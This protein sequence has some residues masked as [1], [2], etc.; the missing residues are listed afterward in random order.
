MAESQIQI[1]IQMDA[2]FSGLTV[3]LTPLLDGGTERQLWVVLDET[4]PALRASCRSAAGRAEAAAGR[5]ERAPAAAPAR[6]CQIHQASGKLPEGPGTRA[7][8]GQPTRPQVEPVDGPSG[9][10]VDHRSPTLTPCVWT[11]SCPHS[12]CPTSF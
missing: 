7:R 6:P 2:F 11:A 8:R 10:W 1:Q 12:G 4:S 5:A 3:D 9:S